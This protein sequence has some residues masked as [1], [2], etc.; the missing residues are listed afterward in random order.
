VEETQ[1]FKADSVWIDREELSEVGNEME[2]V[3]DS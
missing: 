1:A 3:K 2:A